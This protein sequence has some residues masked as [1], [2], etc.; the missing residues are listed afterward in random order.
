MTFSELA[1]FIESEMRM[2]QVYQPVFLALLLDSEGGLITE[3]EA[4]ESFRQVLDTEPGTTFDVRRYPGDVL[5]ERGVV[6]RLEDERYRLIGFRELS[7]HQRRTL[8][9]LCDARLELFLA[10]AELGGEQ[11]GP[12]RLYILMSDATPTLFKLGFTTKRATYRATEIS[13][14]T[15]VPASFNVYY[16]SAHVP[17]AYQREQSLLGEFADARPNP[18]KEFLEMRVL[19]EVVERLPERETAP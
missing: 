4:G 17:D 7:S 18:R 13:R 12:G 19:K 9:D 6:E 10:G 1:K 5:I 16:E 3:A 11:L 14:G 8:I 15:G 2:A